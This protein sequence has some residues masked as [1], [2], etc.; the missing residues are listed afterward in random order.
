M[1]L[2]IV[3]HGEA[4]D[5]AEDRQRVLTLRGERDTQ[6]AA[7]ALATACQTVGAGCAVPQ[8]ILHSPWV[9]TQQTAGLLAERFP[10]ATLEASSA[11]Q[12]GGT[13]GA[14]EAAVES[15]EAQGCKHLMLVSHQPLVSYL[16]SHW[17][18]TAD[19]VPGM[20]PGAFTTMSLDPVGLLCGQLLFWA[21]PPA[22]ALHQ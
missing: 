14:V 6:A 22:Y 16:V 5:A 2:T 9:R 20:M 10:T 13:V 4:A 1:I 8:S 15:A 17:V 12:P 18:E 7:E 19:R 3:R 21:T 11:L